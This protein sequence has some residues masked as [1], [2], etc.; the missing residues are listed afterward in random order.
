MVRQSF[1]RRASVAA[2]Q[3]SIGTSVTAQRLSLSAV[4]GTWDRCALGVADQKEPD[5][6]DE[7]TRRERPEDVVAEVDLPTG[8]LVGGLSAE[9]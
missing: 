6:R 5:H 7:G 4:W 1:W 3:P 8:Q 2:C 9:K